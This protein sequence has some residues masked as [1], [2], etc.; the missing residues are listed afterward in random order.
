MLGRDELKMINTQ[1]D[2]YCKTVSSSKG[3]PLSSSS[4]LVHFVLF[5]PINA[6]FS[7]TK[8]H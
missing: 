8:K 2:R 5:V 6:R 4:A 1:V 7:A 3:I